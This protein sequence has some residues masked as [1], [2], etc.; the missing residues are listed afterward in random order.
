MLVLK[1]DLVAAL[2]HYSAPFIV[3]KLAHEFRKNLGFFLLR[4]VAAVF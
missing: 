3:A 4:D 1:S 2:I